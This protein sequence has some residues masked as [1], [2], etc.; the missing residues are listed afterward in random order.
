MTNFIQNPD[1]IELQEGLLESPKRIPSKYFYD[2][3]GSELFEEIC[4]LDEYYPKRTEIKIIL[5]NIEDIASH[6]NNETVFIELGAGSG[7]KTKIIL[8]AVGEIQAYLPVDI[9]GDYLIQSVKQ[10]QSD[11]PQLKILPVIA[12]YTKNLNLPLEQFK[13]RK[14]IFSYPGSTI[15]NFTFTEARKFLQRLFDISDVGDKLL[16]GVDLLKPTNIL[17]KA[18]NDS[19]GIT[20][21]FNLNILNNVNK[22]LGTNFN[23]DNF[24]HQAIFNEKESR[25]EM[26]LISKVKQTIKFFDKTITIEK[27]EKI[28]TEYSHKYSLE[29]FEKLALPFFK[30]EKVWTD[31][32]NYFSVQLLHVNKK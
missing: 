32:K 21:K 8:K 7:D 31:N 25:I 27:G 13:K 19:K 17:L 26:Y 18:Y 1:F 5:E 11:F 9:S 14:I 10:L 3:R 6:F 22:I 4:N 2:K 20:A 28:L 12:D 15:G 16:I 23:T 29:S 24:Y 30:I